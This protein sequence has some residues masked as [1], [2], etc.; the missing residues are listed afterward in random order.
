MEIYELEKMWEKTNHKDIA[1]MD[2]VVCYMNCNGKE[3]SVI[4]CDD[5][6]FKGYLTLSDAKQLSHWLNK[7]AIPALQSMSPED[8]K[9]I[10]KKVKAMKL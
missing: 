5:I 1:G 4:Y 10:L 6:D 8:R 3:K 9:Q 7:K 2:M